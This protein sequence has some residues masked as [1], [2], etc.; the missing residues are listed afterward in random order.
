MSIRSFIYNKSSLFYMWFA[1][2]TII[3]WIN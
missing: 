2:D 3:N 1:D